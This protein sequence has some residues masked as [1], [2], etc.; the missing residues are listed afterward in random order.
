MFETL[1]YKAEVNPQLSWVS[2]V[3]C[4]I[5]SCISCCCVPS[6]LTMRDPPVDH[7]VN[8]YLWGST[9]LVHW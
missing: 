8:A 1:Y 2:W 9:V 4:A 3:L 7:K 5:V 6:V